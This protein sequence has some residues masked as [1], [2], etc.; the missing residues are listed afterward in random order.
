[1]VHCCRSDWINSL[2]Q[3]KVTQS[4][5]LVMVQED[6]L[7]LDV[8]VDDVSLVQVVDSLEDL[9]ENLPLDLFVLPLWVGL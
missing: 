2:G 8:T 3:A 4:G 7:R 6:V 1:M 9:S 5:I